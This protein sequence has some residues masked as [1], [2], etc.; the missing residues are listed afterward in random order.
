MLM[1]NSIKLINKYLNEFIINIKHYD[2]YL[3]IFLTLLLL[4]WTFYLSTYHFRKKTFKL[5]VGDIAPYDIKVKNDI[6]YIDEIKTEAKQEEIISKISPF[7]QFNTQI[8]EQEKL[9][10]DYYFNKIEEI[11]N[12][13]N[14]I[15][16][17]IQQAKMIG[18]M[19]DNNL[20]NILFLN[21]KLNNF[22]IKI[23]NILD[24][25]Y[26]IGITDMSYDNVKSLSKTG[27]IIK[28]YNNEQGEE[29]SIKVDINDIYYKNNITYSDVIKKYYN[30]FRWDKIQFLET[31]IKEYIHP[32][33][34]FDKKITDEKI[35]TAIN[36]IKP[37]TT[38]LKKGQIIVRDGQ[39]INES[40]F[41]ILKKM[42]KYSSETDILNGYFIVLLMIFIITFL[43]LKTFVKSVFNNLNTFLFLLSF[44]FLSVTLIYFLPNINNF[45]SPKIS[46]AYFIPIAGL[47]VTLNHLIGF[48]I[49]IFVLFFI[50]II[51]MFLIGFNFIDFIVILNSGLFTLL[52]LK[53]FKKRKYI[54]YL[55]II[56]GLFYFIINL[57]LSGIQNYS[58]IQNN[59]SILIG[60]LNGLI[61]VIIS[62]GLY[63]LFENTFNILTE[64]KL[65]ELSDLNLPI[66][67]K[68]LI[69]APGTYNHSILIANMAETASLTINANSLLARVGG[70]YHDI[71]KLGNPEY[72]IENQSGT[73]DKHKKI[74]PS[75]SRSIVKAHIKYGIDLAK[76]LKL[77]EEIIK[78]IQEH[79]GT[80]TIS[81][82]YNKAL[83]AN[84]EENLNKDDL[85]STYRYDGPKP[86]TKEA[87]IIMLADAVEAAS[88]SLKKPS[89]SRLKEV[90]HSIINERFLDGQL[91]NCPLTLIDLKKIENSF[92]QM[93]AAMYHT[94]IEY[95]ERDE[96]KKS[97]NEY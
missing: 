26:S 66:I 78:I 90:V 68:L 80:T 86:H 6:D 39:E 60:F 12:K 79:H 97:E 21:Y 32:N 36:L 71:G 13:Y 55:G 2:L 33:I 3:K 96:V 61:S 4:F 1:K 16:D 58:E 45:L 75:I 82:F 28:I 19:K 76:K 17:K 57:G 69:E 37:V 14:D 30:N 94:R 53:I 70:Y 18:F 25:M 35:M 27:Y 52:L 47:T 87:A 93:L 48:P 8:L 29:I 49:S 81:F 46:N 85:I 72:Y 51:S 40:H 23:K 11:D 74:K 31:Y 15:N 10:V 42:V 41:N 24:K 62:M 59:N 44:I 65:L 54:W 50:S 73:D 20:L 56:I 88:R 63:P 22:N 9:K 38:R 64:Y 67:K 7:F 84:N 5:K 77:P 34:S 83:Q 95:P 43:L 92:S 89:Y 91:N